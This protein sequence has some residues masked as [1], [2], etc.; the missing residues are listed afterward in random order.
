MNAEDRRVQRLQ[1]LDDHIGQALRDSEA[2]G[3]L[4]SAPSWGKPLPAD[5]G[6]ETTPDALRIPFKILKNAG[7]LPPEVLLMHEITAM[8][9]TLDGAGTAAEQQA[10]RR[11]ISD[12]RQHLALRLEKLRHSGSL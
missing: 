12:K 9:Q 3:E 1:L 8:Q 11:Q 6:Y 10:L 2:R 7:V 4:R 5:E